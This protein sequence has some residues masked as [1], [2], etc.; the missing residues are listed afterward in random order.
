ME[1]GAAEGRPFISLPVQDGLDVNEEAELRR[2][3]SATGLACAAARLA[4][5]L[6]NSKMKKAL[7]PS[8]NDVDG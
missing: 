5:V 1:A 7:S 3:V 2:R 8:N 4:C 6:R